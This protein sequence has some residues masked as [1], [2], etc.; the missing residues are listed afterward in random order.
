M[1]SSSRRV[2]ISVVGRSPVRVRDAGLDGLDLLSREARPQ[3][4]RVLALDPVARMEDTIGP[5]TVVG[6][7]EQPFRI[8]VEPA[9]RVEARAL[10][11]HRRRDHVQD[12][13]RGVA[14]TDGGRDAARLV[15]E[16]VFGR[17]GRADDP[18]VDG[19]DR[20]VRI[21]L[22]PELGRLSIDGHSPVGDQD[23]ARPA[24]GDAGRGEDLLESLGRHQPAA[25]P[26]RPSA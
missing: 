16:Q 19:D 22:H 17:G 8:L 2:S 13:L 23:L 9:D 24:R 5:R 21:D 7:D 11:E 10:R 14:I 3:A 1:S 20:L 12:G 15:Q 4:D 25:S 18:T 6:Q 26:V